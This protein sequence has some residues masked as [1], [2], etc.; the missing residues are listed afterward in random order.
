MAQ[1][2]LEINKDSKTALLG[3]ANLSSGQAT[4]I[5]CCVAAISL[6]ATQGQRSKDR[7]ERVQIDCRWPHYTSHDLSL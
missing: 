5:L 2:Y 1:L 3:L 7:E 6:P 4:I